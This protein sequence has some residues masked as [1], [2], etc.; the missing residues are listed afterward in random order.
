M[1]LWFPKECL[2][3]CEN[4]GTKLWIYYENYGKL[5]YYIKKTM[6]LHVYYRNYDTLKKYGTIV[7]N[8]SGTLDRNSLL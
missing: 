7:R 6:V 4:C 2:N 1:E 3:N 5:W 8:Q